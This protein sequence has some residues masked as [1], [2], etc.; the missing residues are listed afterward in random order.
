MIYEAR[1]LFAGAGAWFARALTPLEVDNEALRAANAELMQRLRLLEEDDYA[2]IKNAVID[3][4]MPRT[5]IQRWIRTGEVVSILV[6]KS[7]WP[8]IRSILARA[9]HR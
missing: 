8:S 4:H 2:P 3:T 1:A 6:G 5:T 9:A 7:R